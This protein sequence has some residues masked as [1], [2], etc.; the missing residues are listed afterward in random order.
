MNLIFLEE[1][2]IKSFCELNTEYLIKIDDYASYTHYYKHEFIAEMQTLFESLKL[3]GITSL[4]AKPSKCKFCYP[5]SN[6]Y[7]FHHPET[8]EF[9]IRYVIHQKSKTSFIIEE[10]KNKPILVGENGMPF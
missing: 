5:S 8:D 10:C 2:I 1:H 9:V 4:I 6:A 3:K 7:S